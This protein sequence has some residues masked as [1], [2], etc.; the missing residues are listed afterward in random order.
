M[1]VQTDCG[2]ENGI[3]A[4][5]QCLLGGEVAAHRYSSSHANQELKTGGHIVKGDS[6]PGL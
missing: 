5:L 4:T 3:L 2:T 6:L 1:L